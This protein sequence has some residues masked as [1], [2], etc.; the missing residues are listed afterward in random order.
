[1]SM[2]NVTC[3]LIVE[4]GKILI[5]QNNQYSDHPWKWEF[6]GGKIGDAE[7]AINCIV[8]EIKEELDLT[9]SVVKEMQSVDF[10]YEIKQIR[11][12]PFLCEIADGVIKLHEHVACAWKKL[13]ELGDVDFSAADMKLINQS[14]NISI[15]EE[16]IGKKMH[17]S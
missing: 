12:I 13:E 1:M 9:V 2:I 6:P 17:D 4:N 7:T 14:K 3:A 8:R 15:L 10:D 16:Y 5:T 11:L